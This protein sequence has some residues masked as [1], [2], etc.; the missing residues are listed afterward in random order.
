[1]TREEVKKRIGEAVA[2]VQGCKGPEIPS[3]IADFIGEVSG[4][5]TEILEEMVREKLLV[6]IEYSVPNLPMRLKSFYL[7]AGS[8]V[9]E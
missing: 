7:P 1:M 3:L 8:L 5:L 6:E 2:G 4:E 9:M